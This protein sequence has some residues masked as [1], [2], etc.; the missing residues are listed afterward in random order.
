MEIY[1]ILK[2]KERTENETMFEHLQREQ[3]YLIN[4]MDAKLKLTV[5]E[6]RATQYDK[7][8]LERKQRRFVSTTFFQ[9]FKVN[10]VH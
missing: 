3:D 4:T 10:G 5:S 6:T 2:N 8:L 7:I 1:P 9:L